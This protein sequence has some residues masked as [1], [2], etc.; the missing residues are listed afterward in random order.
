MAVTDKKV[1][2][3]ALFAREP[4]A[5]SIAS[6]PISQAAVIFGIAVPYQGAQSPFP[7]AM[8][9]WQVENVQV[10]CTAI[11][12]TAQVDI[13]CGTHAAPVT[14]LTGLITPVAGIVTQ[15]VLVAPSARRF[16]LTDEIDLKCTTNGTGTL[17]NLM[18]TVTIRPF[19]LDNEAA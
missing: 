6:V 15:G 13:Q 10:F 7:Y 9:G 8:K 3:A 19:P 1:H 4:F 17:T 11:A 5:F 14:V 16:N 12:A 2:F 18:V